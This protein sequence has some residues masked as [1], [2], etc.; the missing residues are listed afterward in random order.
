V[1]ANTDD[2][3]GGASNDFLFLP[4]GNGLIEIPDF[5]NGAGAIVFVDPTTPVTGTLGAATALVGLSAGDGAGNGGIGIFA[6]YYLVLSPDYDDGSNIDAGAVTVGNNLTGITGSISGG[7]SFLGLNGGDALGS[8]GF[9]ALNSGNALVHSPD[10]DGG[11]GAVTFFDLL[12][13]NIA[14]EVGFVGAV[15]VDNSFVGPD[16]GDGVGSG[17]IEIVGNHF[18]VLSPNLGT[19]SGHGAVTVADDLGVS[20]PFG[21]VDNTNSLLGGNSGDAVGSE[22]IF[23]LANGNVLILSPG[24]DSGKGAVTFVDL[25]NGTLPTGF[26][27]ATNSLLGALPG[28]EIGFDGSTATVDEFFAGA[29]HY[30]AVFSGNFQPGGAV[31]FGD[32]ASGISGVVSNANSLVGIG[33]GDDVGLITN[34]SVADFEQLS[35]GNLVLLHPGWNDDAGAATF[36]DLVNAAGLTGTI[37]AGN[38]AIGA[39]SGDRVGSD[40]VVELFGT[41]LFAV[42]SPDWENG[43]QAQAGA[44]TWGDIDT[45]VIGV[46]GPG[47]SLVGTVSGDNPGSGGIFTAFTSDAQTRIVVESPDWD[48]G[49]AADAG[50]ITTFLPATPTVGA[51]GAANSFVGGNA[52][53]RVGDGFFR[54]LSNNNRLVVT[55]TWNNDAGAVTFWNTA[56]NLVGTLG[57]A[58]SLVGGNTDDGVGSGTVLEDFGTDRYYV[59]T[60]SWNG[61]R[62]AVT[63]GSITTGRTGVVGAGNSLVG[64]N[65]GDLVGEA[66]INLSFTDRLLVLSEDWN[67]ARG[68][69]TVLN[70]LA[71]TVG[72]VSAANSLVG[73]SAGDRVGDFSPL[74][75]FSVDNRGLVVL[76][77][78]AFGNGGGAVTVM[79]PLAPR[80]GVV[81]SANSLVGRAGDAVGSA[82]VNEL[83]NG[84]LLVRSPLWSDGAGLNFGAVTLMLAASQVT[85]VT[86]FVSATNS[87]V[88]SHAD[89]QVGNGG[90]VTL[91]TG[92]LVVRSPN[93][94]DNRGAV[95]F[96]NIAEG[97]TGAVS[98][99]NSIVGDLA[100]DFVGSGGITQL[101]GDRALIRSPL[102]SVNGI[103]GAG[104]LDILDGSTV[105]E[106]DGNIGFATNPGSELTLSIASLVAFL[107]SG[108]ALLLQ[109]NNDIYLPAGSG[110]VADRGSITLEA[111]RSIDIEADLIVGGDLRLLANAPAANLSFRDAGDGNVTVTAGENSVRVRGANL[112]V[113][114]QNIFVTGGTAPGAFAALIGTATTD[115]HAHGSGLLRLEGGTSLAPSGF[116]PTSAIDLLGGFLNNPASVTAPAAFVV[117]LAGLTVAADEVALIGG[118]SPGAFAAL[119]S[120]GDFTVDTIDLFFA[121]GSAENADALLLGLGGA[122]NISFTSCSGCNELLFDPLL[123]GSS[124]SGIFISGLLQEPTV[125]AILAMVN[126]DAEASEDDDEDDEDEGAAEC[127]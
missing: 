27:N 94:F 41:G 87:L 29:N 33:A 13:G 118:G 77:T 50:A 48:N 23:E 95:T 112:A 125:D 32:A 61:D 16:P 88:G 105:Q 17:G 55:S 65:A 113:E 78:T 20:S 58:N 75:L 100:N 43:G 38:S 64:S 10:F 79:D 3:V 76:R 72:A 56:T 80:L 84:S 66:V 24:W 12:N 73:A 109:A 52:D 74:Q 26:V 42:V 7:N 124:Q 37:G 6:D 90:F 69:V 126:R 57:A 4:S 5:A 31:T 11:A 85:P 9:F 67:A 97:R 40:G 93:W 19:S 103:A 71:P 18:I 46:V 119:A 49:G 107:N 53:D 39:T 63:I 98:G 8:G 14:G 47:N 45:G 110:I 89:D 121:P 68:A 91:T 60:P 1:G 115:I 96:I 83:S 54:I 81:S 22:G 108:A 25:V 21:T 106:L 62:G 36:V 59:S 120:F 99:A 116:V 30:Y 15:D 123:D 70:P 122:A 51:I 35:N 111:G 102:A 34:S 2:D 44:L 127:N 82:G 28:D 114:A 86:G 101:G 92:N 104:R 117:G